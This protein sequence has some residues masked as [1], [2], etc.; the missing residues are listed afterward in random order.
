MTNKQKLTGATAAV[1]AIAIA[2]IM[3]VRHGDNPAQ[4]QKVRANAM[5]DEQIVQALQD[6]KV[7]VDGLLVRSVGGVVVVRGNGDK[8]AVEN[9]LKTLNVQRVANLVSPAY[10]GDDEAIRREAE[11]QLA[12]TRALDGCQLRV[13][14]ERGI[15]R[16]TGTVQREIQADAARQVLRGIPGAREVKIELVA[17]VVPVAPAAL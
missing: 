15:I 4:S 12:S 1:A 17:P 5:G 16:V 11:R 9:V 14:C 2:S 13:S 7:N 3:V 6:A 10:K 8:A